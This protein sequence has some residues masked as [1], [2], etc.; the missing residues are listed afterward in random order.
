MRLLLAGGGT[1]G[2]L[3]PAV[4][5]AQL[6]LQQDKD[7]A[8]QFVGTKMGLEAKLLPKLDLP[9]ATVGMA[10]V[11]GTGWRG[12][13]EMLPRLLKSMLQAKKIINGFKPDLVIG[14]GGYSSVPV[15]LMAKL[16]GIPYVI[17]EQNAIPGLSNKLLG[18][19]AKRIF[20]SFA[21]SG[22][23]FN[24]EKTMLT[25]NPLRSGLND[26]NEKI[27]VG[28][29]LLI[30]GGSRGAQAINKS[31]VEMLPLLK[32]W[33]DCPNILHQ[34]GEAELEKVRQAYADA[35]FDPQQVV[36]FIDDMAAAYDQAKLIVCRAG[37]TT[38]AE[39]TACGRPAIL[40]PFPYAAG[41]HQTANAR[42]LEQVGAAKVLP[43]SELTASVLFELIKQ[44]SGNTE[45]LQSMA[46]KGRSLGQPGA[47]EMILD[48]CFRLCGAK[49]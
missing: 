7:A 4:A 24:A 11:V 14:V 21:D 1:G 20:L 3:F 44:M 35:G 2:H 10:G 26:V 12:K 17:H 40:I 47:A 18:K 45:L 42:T 25:G 31:V 6:L 19:W 28:G 38:L 16:M 13:L 22:K 23:G 36:P 43:Q 8:V 41:D 29:T 9:L 37:A 30:F 49:G 32:A 48:E 34:T 39:L 15:L 27:D 33:S 46:D 5:L